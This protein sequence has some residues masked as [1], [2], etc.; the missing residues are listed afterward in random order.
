MIVIDRI[1]ARIGT[2]QGAARITPDDRPGKAG[3]QRGQC[4][5]RLFFVF[6]QFVYGFAWVHLLGDQLT[7]QRTCGAGSGGSGG[8]ALSLCHH[9]TEYGVGHQAR[10]L[11]VTRNLL[12]LLGQVG[13]RGTCQRTGQVA[14][15]Q[16]LKGCGHRL[17][18]ALQITAGAIGLHG[19]PVSGAIAHSRAIS[20]G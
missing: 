11:V 18:G 14:T 1:F 16:A 17:G 13:R 6:T 7:T 9:R 8:V 3:R 4:R 20:F 2:R 10:S 19:V 5:N 12:D 15:C